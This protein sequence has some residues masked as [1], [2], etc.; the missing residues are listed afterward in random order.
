MCEWREATGL[1]LKAAGF[2]SEQLK[3]I[4][5]LFIL[6]FLITL[7]FIPYSL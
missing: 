7:H 3:F 6:Q 1:R 4:T 5:K 2:L